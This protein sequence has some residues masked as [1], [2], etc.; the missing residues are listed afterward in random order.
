MQSTLVDWAV[1]TLSLYLATRCFK[2]LL[3]VQPDRFRKRARFDFTSPPDQTY[4]D[5]QINL[6]K[7]ELLSRLKDE[8]TSLAFQTI[9]A[10]LRNTLN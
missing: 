8:G 4:L 5:A 10:S 6:A 9:L 2:A 7:T 3:L 1:M